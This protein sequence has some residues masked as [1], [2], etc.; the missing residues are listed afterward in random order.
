[1]SKDKPRLTAKQKRFV[2]EFAADGNAV[3]A[4][5]RAFGRKTA[6]G[7]KRSYDAAKTHAAELITKPHLLAEI[8]AA[9]ADYARKTRVSKLRTIREIAIIA[10]MDPDD[11]FEDNPDDS[12]RPI[13]RPWKDIPPAAR[14]TIL[15]MK[16][17]RKSLVSPDDETT[18]EV[19]EIEIKFHS[20]DTAL[21]KLCKKLGFYADAK[22]DGV[23]KAD[24]MVI[25]GEA[26]PKKL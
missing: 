8:E 15:G 22:D 2:E 20:K 6:R 10:Y 21:D 26:D 16:F 3:Q 17:K 5:F 9:N 13:V 25:G 14:R 23:K 18:W 24:P 12:G 19:E 7:K 11:V 1:M 4:Y